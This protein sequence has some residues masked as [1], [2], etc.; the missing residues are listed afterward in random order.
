MSANGQSTKSDAKKGVTLPDGG[1]TKLKVR[2]R[3]IVIK[4]LTLK[5]LQKRIDALYWAMNILRTPDQAP[6]YYLSSPS[7]KAYAQT[8][9]EMYRAIVGVKNA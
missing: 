3:K 1:P 4:T 6:K 5:E 9:E 7:T 2:G 8:L